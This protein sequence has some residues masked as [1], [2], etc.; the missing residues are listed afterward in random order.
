MVPNGGE[1]WR[2]GAP[3]V[4]GAGGALVARR[5]VA[6]GR[7]GAARLHRPRASSGL[8]SDDYRGLN[9]ERASGTARCK[10]TQG[11]Q[12]ATARSVSS[13]NKT[14]VFLRRAEATLG[15]GMATAAEAG[16]NLSG[17]G[18]LQSGRQDLNPAK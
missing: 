4:S 1:A 13:A 18:R 2:D 3:G 12:D 5:P 6:H 16:E 7:N 14:P 8:A 17:R 9:T 15:D 10:L 11:R